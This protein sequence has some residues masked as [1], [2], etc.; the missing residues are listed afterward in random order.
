MRLG[1]YSLTRE[2]LASVARN[3]LDSLRVQALGIPSLP[4]ANAAEIAAEVLRRN[5]RRVLYAGS[6]HFHYMWVSDFGK[7]LRGALRALPAAYLRRQVSWMIRESSRLGRVPSVFS[8]R[9]GFDMPY[10]RGDNL[11]WLVISVAE[12]KRWTGEEPAAAE[13]SALSALLTDYGRTYLS[14]GLLPQSVT[15]DWVDTI[16]RPSSTYNNVCVLQMLRKA[17]SLGLA[18]PAAPEEFEDRLLGERWRDGMLTDHAESIEPG[19]DAAAWALYFGLFDEARRRS[20]ARVIEASGLVR[21][22][23]LRVAARRHE[24]RLMPPLT[25]LSPD[26]HNCI[27]LHLGLAYLNGLKRLGADVSSAK[28]ALSRV[29]RTHRNF[30]ESFTP[31]GEPYRTPL[32]STEYG[33]TMAAG[34]YLELSLS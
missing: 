17:R 14:Q 19:V 24:A 18:V 30:V 3:T 22:F 1:P 28:A 33:L 8:H 9:R 32:F 16:L 23:P 31:A 26:Y 10:W 29:V 13:R 27:W 12:L 5:A 11:P 21:P 15:G 6:G 7:A 4:G 25:R 20:M 2:S 34:Q